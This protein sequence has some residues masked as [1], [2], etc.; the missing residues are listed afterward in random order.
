[1]QT[2]IS[3]QPP[4]R[5]GPGLAEPEKKVSV[6]PVEAHRATL[7]D[8]YARRSKA[9]FLD[10]SMLNKEIRL[11]CVRFQDWITRIQQA[12][13]AIEDRPHL[14][15]LRD[16][17]VDA[18]AQTAGGP[19]KRCLKYGGATRLPKLLAEFHAQF[20]H[21]DALMPADPG[22]NPSIAYGPHN[23]RRPTRST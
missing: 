12:A 8:L 5:H 6:H 15:A 3:F 16:Q 13:K 22:G 1:M 18:E 21:P 20:P 2:R 17:V 10:A 23:D 11:E 7:S 14:L 4:G 9:N 19:V